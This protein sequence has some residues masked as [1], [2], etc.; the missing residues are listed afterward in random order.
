MQFSTVKAITYILFFCVYKTTM[1]FLFDCREDRPAQCDLLLR[2]NELRAADVCDGVCARNK[3]TIAGT[4]LQRACHE[5]SNHSRTH[6]TA[7]HTL[8]SN[9]SCTS[10]SQVKL[11]SETH[12]TP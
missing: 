1:K 10:I 12:G 11:I 5:V 2:G 3:G 4:D 9:Q 7:I 8:H 6:Y